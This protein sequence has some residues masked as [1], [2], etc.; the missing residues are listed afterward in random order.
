MNDLQSIWG[1]RFYHYMREIQ[2]YMQYIFTGHLGIV[3]VF[4]IGAAGYAYSE[5]L[6]EVPVDFPSAILVAVVIGGALVFSA[7]VT[8]LKPADLIFFLPL[9]KELPHYMKRSLRWSIFSQMP[10]PIIIYIV[11][12]PLLSATITNSTMMLLWIA[13]FIFVLKWAFV[14]TEFAVRF[15]KSGQGVW[16]DRVI[17]FIIAATFIYFWLSPTPYLIL[18][19]TIGLGAYLTYWRKKMN[20]N[21]FPYEHFIKL[22][23][24]RMMRFYRFA[25]Y[26]TDV[27]HLKGAVS[28]RS[29]LGFLMKRPSFGTTTAQSFLVRRTFIRTDDTFWL[30]VRLT[31][32]AMVGT[33]F[34]AIPIAITILVGALA[35]ASSIQLIYALQ[36]GDAF[37]MDML[38]PESSTVREEVIRRTVRSAQWIQACLVFIISVLVFQISL[39]AAVPALVIIAVSEITI[40]STKKKEND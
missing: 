31:L 14:E 8:L 37:R 26:F 7:P 17:R 38:F 22:E 33:Y 10:L 39:F 3:L 21:P 34:I 23:Q 20:Q 24:N 13:V 40:R 6:K 2:K 27:P 16:Q 36:S 12:L 5:W 28:R 30:W 1:K 4:A 19:P 35:F 18:I 25:N 29:W 11:A 32:I 9:E 15:T